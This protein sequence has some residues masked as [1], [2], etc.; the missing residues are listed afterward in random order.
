[1]RVLDPY[2]PAAIWYDRLSGER[3]VYG[4]GRRAGLR[5]LAPPR[6]AVVLDLGCGTGLNLPM[7]LHA[8]GPAGRVIGVDASAPMLAQAHRRIR[9]VGE[10]VRLIHADATR[11]E[12]E[13]VLAV[14]GFDA[15]DAVVATYALSVMP[16]PAEAWRRATATMRRGG[17][18]AVIDL[19]RPTG[20]CRPLGPIAVAACALGGSD[21]DARP[22]RL[23]EAA[24]PD[25]R[26]VEVR[27]GHIRAVAGTL[28][29]TPDPR[30][31]QAPVRSAPRT[32][33]S[34]E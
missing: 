32:I 29:P 9:R 4:A 20:R 33:E 27:C 25:A 14:G 17:R 16:D 23:L 7:L 11:L 19:Q 18:A 6:G 5:L 3:A 31:G 12:P 26:S 15:V 2:G 34:P 21:I 13:E 10:R 30:D 22:W 24:A 28:G 1:M 8:V